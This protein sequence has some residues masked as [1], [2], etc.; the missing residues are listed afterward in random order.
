ML[1][2]RI[3]MMAACILMGMLSCESKKPSSIESTIDSTYNINDTASMINNI[4]IYIQY[5]NN[6]K[7][8]SISHDIYESS[9]GGTNVIYLSLGDT[10]KRK[11]TFYGENGKRII[12]AFYKSGDLMFVKDKMVYYKN[13]IYEGVITDID[14]SSVDEYYLENDGK[15]IS[16]NSNGKLIPIESYKKQQLI[17]SQIKTL[18]NQSYNEP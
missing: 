11:V 17:I 10:V 6:Q 1:G 5:V 2:Y 13:P 18:V 12:D 8:D 4:N 3:H 9:E 16:W 7:F 14:S 15:I